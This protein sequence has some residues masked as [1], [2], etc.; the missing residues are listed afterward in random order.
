[1]LFT[2]TQISEPTNPYR[3]K[4]HTPLERSNSP[5]YVVHLPSP[6]F[7]AARK[8]QGQA[9]DQ[10]VGV[11][12]HNALKALYKLNDSPRLYYLHDEMKQARMWEF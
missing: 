2:M 8:R 12:Y 1:M 4:I 5:G 6:E 7:I 10:G 11:A 9:T 3:K